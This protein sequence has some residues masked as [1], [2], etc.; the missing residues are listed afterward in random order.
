MKKDKL[1]FWS[2]LSL[3]IIV[4]A[5]G[6]FSINYLIKVSTE[7]FLSI[8]IA[9]SK[10]EAQE[11]A[12]M[13]SYQ[14]ENGA[15][16]EK[17]IRNV[18]N[19]IK[20]TE[21][22]AGFL[23]MFDASGKE[24]CNP[25]PKKIGVVVKMGES[26]VTSSGN[27]NSR[28][29]LSFLTDKKEGGG[30]RSFKNSDRK[31]EIIYTY[32]VENSEFIMAA[33]ANFDV[34]NNEIEKLKTSFLLV[35]GGT[36]FLIVLMSLFAIRLVGQKYEKTLENKNEALSLE[37]INLANL[38]K[39]I[40]LYKEKL[41]TEKPREESKKN[42][43]LTYVSDQLI[44]IDVANIALI[45]TENSVTYFK[46]DSGAISHSN[47]SLDVIFSNLDP[48]V[49]FRANRQNIISINAIEKVIKY[50]NNQL[51]IETNPKSLMEII[52]GKN[53]AA[54]FKQWLDS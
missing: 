47:S 34:L 16:K 53:K 52:I 20:D 38:N 1:Y 36:S 10:R 46:T 24:V 27:V 23:C 44:P 41:N 11:M 12:K 7:Q 54:E 5:V 14:I 50:G 22:Q 15:S 3:L 25:N 28:D 30:I 31:S 9:A 37:V 4:F 49:F 2:F 32:P 8:Q 42:R 39:N 17:I 51:K 18:Q 33:H 19:S 45:Y 43:I 13:V 48:Q 35:Y 29:F 40:D 26:F 21:T 6:Y